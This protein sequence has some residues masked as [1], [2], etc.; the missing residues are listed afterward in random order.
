MRRREML[1]TSV[2]AAVAAWARTSN[3]QIF[4]DT[5]PLTIVV[6]FAPGGGS[7]IMARALSVQL[8][9]ALGVSVIVENRPGAS[10]VVAT[11]YV[12]ASV[13]DCKTLL[14]ADMGFSA[15]TSLYQNAGYVAADFAPVAAVASVSSVLVVGKN[16]RFKTV[17]DLVEQGRAK[18]GSLNMASGG[19]GGTAHLIGYMFA[20]QAHFQPTHV[21]YR[22][23]GPAMT[24]VLGGQV[25]FLVA[26]APTAIPNVRA[27]GA[28]ALAVTSAKR[29]AALPDV[30][31]FAEAGYPGVL[32]DDVY[33]LVAPAKCNQETIARLN[34]A[35]NAIVETSTYK[36]RL[37]GLYAQAFE[38]PSCASYGA[39]LHAE[40]NR[41]K[42]VIVA[43]GI[44]VT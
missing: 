27:G 23:M 26:T 3:A 21:P 32:A 5:R 43:N 35:I 37:A 4:S 25:D 18:P 20:N 39:F 6:P 38:F 16:S 29:L 1:K 11:R 28:R 9:A 13:A 33:G 12:K 14:I 10:G 24:D 8:G 17:A 42:Q 34:T 15:N 31:T 36:A 22:G 7:D 41:W 40:V 19:S 30:P 44:T 2:A